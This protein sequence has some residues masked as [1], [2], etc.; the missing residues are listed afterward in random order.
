[1][2]MISG[3]EFHKLCQFSFCNRYPQR[4]DLSQLQENDFVFMNFD[5]FDQ[6]YIFVRKF[7][8]KLPKFNLITH[9]SDK[10]FRTDHY[11]RIKPYISK[12]YC[13]NCDIQNNPDI[14]KIP[15]GFVDDKYKPHIILNNVAQS[16]LDKS[17]FCYLNF[18]IRT[19]PVERQSCYDSLK[20]APWITCEFNIP[21][22]DFYVAIKKSRYVISPDGTGY[23]CH[24]IYESILFDTITIIKRNPLSDFYD[25]LPVLQVDAWSDLN[26]GILSSQYDMLYKRMSDWKLANPEWTTARFWCK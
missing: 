13:I 22:K 23:D 16:F 19:N 3:H 17:I 1:M 26:E 12:I 5:A 10:T 20:N 8:I 14:I 25:T 2:A 6:F 18:A 9:N 4:T 15:L 7:R 24:R 21:P 11:I